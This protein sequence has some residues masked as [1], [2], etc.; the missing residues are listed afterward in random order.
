M[1]RKEDAIAVKQFGM[2]DPRGLAPRKVSALKE[3]F[4][5]TLIVAVIALTTCFA[6]LTTV[7]ADAF[8]VL[9]VMSYEENNPWCKEIKQ[10]ID[11]VLSGTS[12]ITY[13]YMDTKVNIEDGPK[14]AEDAYALFRQMEPDGLITV[15]DNAQSL[16]VLPY[17]KHHVE[18][19]VMFSGVNA[20]A[21]KYG[22]PT[23]N[24]SGILERGHIRES[25]ALAKQLV[26]STRSV[27]FLAKDSP[28]GRA[29]LRQVES[30]SDTYLVK[31]SFHLIESVNDLSEIDEVLSEQSDVIYVDSM[32]GVKG[33][34]G[35]PLRYRTM[36]ELLTDRYRKPII[37]ANQ[38][39][40][41]QGALCS[42]VKT[43]QEQGRTAAEMLQKAMQGAAVKE[44]PVVQNYQ[45]KRV[46]NVTA[47]KALNLQVK[48]IVLVG[49]TLIKSAQ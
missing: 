45:G 15:D 11:S 34:E 43:G 41:E 9:V 16:F 17:L 39:H 5:L 13:F 44:L 37:G 23:P 19:P 30:E 25:I 21:E 14:K 49:A 4:R 31:T 20:D 3:R 2:L 10:G 46:I 32:Q 22:F 33:P 18:T 1:G 36:I 47:I 35:N 38:H 40:V 24:I 6:S 7:Q 27:A 26:P 28:S 8:K 29:L 42:V 48:P 12:D